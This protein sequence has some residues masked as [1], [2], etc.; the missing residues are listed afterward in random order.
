M[1][2]WYDWKLAAMELAREDTAADGLVELTGKDVPVQR[3]K[4][5]SEMDPPEVA[6]WLPDGEQ[7]GEVPAAGA[8]S[9]GTYGGLVRGDILVPRGSEGLEH[10]IFERLQEV[11][12]H[13]AFAGKGVDARFGRWTV[14]DDPDL[15]GRDRRIVFEVRTT[16][17][18]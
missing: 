13:Q 3:D 4:A 12:T 17:M 5:L 6:F 15:Q 7:T 1:T 8:A 10:R 14:R 16:F 11:W 9:A 2:T 18:R